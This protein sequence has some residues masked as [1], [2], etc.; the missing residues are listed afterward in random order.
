M[1]NRL[2]GSEVDSFKLPYEQ[3]IA[4]AAQALFDALKNMPN[5]EAAIR[6]AARLA[7]NAANEEQNSVDDFSQVQLP[8]K[9]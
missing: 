3:Q 2:E 9:R 1:R 8:I 5:P 7:T 6:V 4:L